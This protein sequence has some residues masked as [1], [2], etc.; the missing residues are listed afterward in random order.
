MVDV[1]RGPEPRERSGWHAPVTVT[2]AAKDNRR[3]ALEWV[4]NALL[5][6]MWCWAWRTSRYTCLYRKPKEWEP[7]PGQER[8]AECEPETTTPPICPNCAAPVVEKANARAGRP[9]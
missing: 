8:A 6:S 5:F 1:P 9:F 2:E 3:L 4:L 7:R